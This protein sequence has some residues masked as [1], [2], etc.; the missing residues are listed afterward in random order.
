MKSKIIIALT[1][2]ITLAVT[3][4]DA[5]SVRERRQ[6][7][8]EGIAK[9]YG[10]GKISKHDRQRL[11]KERHHFRHDRFHGRHD[12]KYSYRAKRYQRYDRNKTGRSGYSYRNNQRRF[13]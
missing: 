4:V 10:R 3:S 7:Q 13:D 5:Q 6:Y 2:L 12:R 9:D 11:A 1:V 8:R